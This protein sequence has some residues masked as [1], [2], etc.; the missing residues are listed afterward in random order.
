M[1]GVI[2]PR[3]CGKSTFL[4]D[5]ARV[6]SL[7]ALDDLSMREEAR[8]SPSTFLSKL[9][10]PCGI[11]EVQKAPELFDAIKLSVDQDRRPGRFFL[12]GSTQFSA[13]LGIR[14]SLTGRIGLLELH[15]FT[16]AELHA[17]PPKDHSAT[18]PRFSVDQALKGALSGGMPVPAFLRDPIQRALYWTSWLETTIYRDLAAFF[19]R[20]YDPDLAMALLRRMGQ[21]F[22]EGELPTLKHFEQPALQVRTY[23]S[24]MEDLFLVRRISCHPLGT[25]KEVW[26]CFD[27]GLAAHL[28]EDISGT[29]A[30]LSLVRHFLWNE[31]SAQSAMEGR[32]MVREYFKSAQGAPVDLI[33]DR[34]PYKIVPTV[35]AATRQRAWEERAVRAAMKKLGSDTGFLIAPLDRA[36]LPPDGKG[37]GIL[38]WSWWS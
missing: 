12:T 16:L 19:R 29:G 13:K 1:V 14:E 32:R 23:L 38:P 15:P 28:M 34:I 24:A 2:G 4:R 5:L 20:S 26:I 36:E 33:H 30:T 9:P 35:A 17:T 27:S 21:V 8:L 3:Q 6:P 25:G 18:A 22:R 31:W 11:D 10:E 37:V 7:T